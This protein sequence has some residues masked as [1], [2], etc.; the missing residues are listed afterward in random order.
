MTFWVSFGRPFPPLAGADQGPPRVMRMG[1]RRAPFVRRFGRPFPPPAGA[2]QSPLQVAAMGARGAP[3]PCRFARLLGA[4]SRHLGGPIKAPC[5]WREWAPRG[6]LPLTVLGAFWAPNPATRGG[7][8][9]PPVG[10][11]NGGPK[12]AFPLRFGSLAGFPPPPTLCVVLH[13][14]CRPPLF[15]ACPQHLPEMQRQEPDDT[16]RPTCHPLV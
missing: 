12:G 9:R 7:R 14:A 5:W 16:G 8:S 1:A 11:G 13:L 4:H 6:C 2:D 3:S 15:G 10:G